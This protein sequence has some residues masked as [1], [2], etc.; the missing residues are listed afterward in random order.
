MRTVKKSCHDEMTHVSYPYH[1][2]TEDGYC[3]QCGAWAIGTS[4]EYVVET[5]RWLSDGRRTV[6]VYGEG[7][8]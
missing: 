6:E 5:G 3:A 8:K 4:R 7:V 1:V 2:M